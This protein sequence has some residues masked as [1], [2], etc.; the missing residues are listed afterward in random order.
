MWD[1][2]T[3]REVIFA[4]IDMPDPDQFIEK[5]VT[6]GAFNCVRLYAWFNFLVIDSMERDTGLPISRL[7][8]CAEKLRHS[9]RIVGSLV[10][11]KMEQVDRRIQRVMQ[12]MK[13]QVDVKNA[14]DMIRSFNLIKKSEPEIYSFQTYYSTYLL[15]LI[16][17]IGRTPSEAR[18]KTLSHI[19]NLLFLGMIEM[20]D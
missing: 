6:R 3:L 14:Q 20:S 12:I 4:L 13:S 10:N 16:E 7:K 5:I 18:L 19:L 11:L 15:F 1:E 17:A 9:D 2:K 8:H